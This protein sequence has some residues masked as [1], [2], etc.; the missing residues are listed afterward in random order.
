[1]SGD[2]SVN[3]DPIWAREVSMCA[4]CRALVFSVLLADH[5][6]WHRTMTNMPPRG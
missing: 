6:E 5:M 4:V 2:R 3:P 1:M